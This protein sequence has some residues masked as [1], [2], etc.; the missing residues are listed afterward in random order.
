MKTISNLLAGF[1]AMASLTMFPLNGNAQDDKPAVGFF[2]IVNVVAPGAGK[3][4]IVIDGE[5]IFPKG[6]DLGQRTGGIGVKAGAHSITIKKSG[7]EPGVTKV[8]VGKG[9]TLSLIAFAQKKPVEKEGDPPVWET[10]ILHLKQSD[11]EKGYRMAIISLCSQD[12]IK[13]TSEARG[14]PKPQVVFAKRLVISNVDM[15]KSKADAQ[16][17]VA[18]EIVA[19]VM[20]EEPGNYVVILYE[21]EAGRIKALSFYDPKF[22][23]AS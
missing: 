22:V 19:R 6:Y 9:E 7:V 15:G 23:I 1:G 21:D 14:K 3:V 17:S 11:P 10:K 4:S 5:D 16:L 8:T 18:G 20:P 2:R 13:V 12:E